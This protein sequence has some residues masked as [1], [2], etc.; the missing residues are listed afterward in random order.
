MPHVKLNCQVLNDADVALIIGT[1]LSE[2]DWWGKPP[3]WR[4]PSEQTTIQVDIDG[5]M[6]GLNKPADLAILADAKCFLEL[7]GAE[8]ARHRAACAWPGTAR[9]CATTA[10][11][12]TR[13]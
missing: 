13:H 6:L 9:R 5:D 1:R 8:L 7:L 3:Y 10:R 4:H 2:T 11:A 12:G